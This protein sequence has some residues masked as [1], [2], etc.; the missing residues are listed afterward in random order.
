M[1][2]RHTTRCCL[3][4]RETHRDSVP[5]SRLCGPVDSISG[6]PFADCANRLIPVAEAFDKHGFIA[7]PPAINCWNRMA[8]ERWSSTSSGNLNGRYHTNTCRS[9]DNRTGLITPSRIRPGN[10][11]IWCDEYASDELVG[12]KPQQH[13]RWQLMSAQVSNVFSFG[14]C[15]LCPEKLTIP[16]IQDEADKVIGIRNHSPAQCIRRHRLVVAASTNRL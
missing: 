13:F 3:G 16:L 5:H 12:A 4:Y 7:T 6:K 11:R 14:L 8:S 9:P 10:Y 15:M 1:F 2:G